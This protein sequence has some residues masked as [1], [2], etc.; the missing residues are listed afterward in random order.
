MIT[1]I[2]LSSYSIECAVCEREWVYALSEL[3]YG[4]PVY[5]GEIL[6]DDD[7]GEWGGVPVCPHCYYLVRGLQSEHKGRFPL[8]VVRRLIPSNN[9]KERT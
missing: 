4:I 5:E 8:H 2:D 1:S 7:P 6:P 3:K 9:L